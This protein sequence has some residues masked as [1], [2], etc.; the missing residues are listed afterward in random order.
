M[1]SNHP[2]LAVE[3]G[4]TKL[5]ACVA[6]SSGEILRSVR[7]DVDVA[8]GVPG[9]LAWVQSACNELLSQCAERPEAVGVGFGGPIDTATGEVLVSHQISGWQGVRLR[10][11][12]EQALK[13]PAVVANDANAAGWAEFC[14][15]AGKG[16]HTFC[17]CN[18]GSG[19]GGAL[20]VDGRLLDGQGRGAAEIGHTQVPDWRGAPGASAR[21]EDLCSGWSL[22]KRVRCEAP[23]AP[24]SPLFRLCDGNRQ[25]ITA[26]V[27]AEAARAGDGY[28]QEEIARVGRTVGLALANVVTLVHPQVIAMGG[29]V[30]L[31]GDL[32]L[33]PLRKSVHEHAF[34]VFRESVAIV[35]CALGED[36]V[37]HGAAL[38]AAAI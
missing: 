22:E 21:L 14:L 8:A 16:L 23:M 13:L 15:G 11:W 24:K 18:I 28:A 9:I 29:G 30:S 7:G 36:V 34:G 1:P 38:L 35:P 32:L 17:Y 26:R 37:L 25:R 12:F 4:G 2:V 19:I 10:E 3:I 33:D 27:L 6:E 5:Q 20:V 31:M